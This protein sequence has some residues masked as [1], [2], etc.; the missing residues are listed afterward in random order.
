MVIGKILARIEGRLTEW[1]FV[2]RHRLTAVSVLEVGQD[3]WVGPRAAPEVCCHTKMLE[4]LDEMK[5]VLVV[6]G[7]TPCFG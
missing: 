6:E 2:V 1:E 7:T 3:M 5:K 4:G